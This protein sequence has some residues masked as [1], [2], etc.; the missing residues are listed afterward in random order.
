MSS[1]IPTDEITR[2]TDLDVP[3]DGPLNP[4]QGVAAFR[5]SIEDGEY[6]YDALLHVISR[7]VVPTEDVD[8]VRLHYLIAGEAFDWL[9]LAQR[10]IG[11]AEDLIPPEQAE[12]LLVEGMP[13]RADTEDEFERAI[14][15]SKYRAHLNFQYGVV[16][17]EL[18]LLSAEL[19]LN[20][21]GGLS[22]HGAHPADIEAFE[23][24]YGKP[25]DELRVIYA[26]EQGELLPD[27]LSQTEM[28][29]FIYWL[30]KFRIRH[31][32]PARIASDTRKA[33]TV[34]ARLEGNR[35]RMARLRAAAERRSVL[36]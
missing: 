29:T 30:S 21:L 32:E 5:A 20:K 23:R 10:L 18:L 1:T 34:L 16:V 2:L 35:A 36:G 8:G 31:A 22:R 25:L 28:R 3:E 17:E 9:L 24:V 12:Q 7:W 11:A 27:R 6:W 33:M 13:P 4:E 14:G 19:E 15:P 26:A